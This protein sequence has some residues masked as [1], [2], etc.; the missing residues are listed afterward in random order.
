[1]LEKIFNAHNKWINTVLKFGCSQEEAEDIVG[2]MYCI[3]GKMLTKGLDISYGDDVNYYYIYLT[4]KTSFL[5]LKK[6]KEKEGK[7]SIDLV[8]NLES[9]EY[10]DFETEN[11]KVEDELERLHWYDRKVY[12]MIQ[13]EYTIT[14]LSNKTT[15]SYHSLYNTFRKVK[16]RLKQKINK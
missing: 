1:M 8:Y 11:N 3:I 7:K 6:R 9:G 14:E 16:K 4:L 10:I 12:N 5:Q 2:D 13:N 15:I